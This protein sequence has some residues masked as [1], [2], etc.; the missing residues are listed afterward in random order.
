[1]ENA[2]NALLMAA[3]VLIGVMIISLAVYLFHSFADYSREMNIK[4]E[5]TILDEFNN[6]FLK[7][8]DTNVTLHDILGLASLAKKYDDEN[9]LT[10]S[11][12]DEDGEKSTY[13]RIDIGNEKFIEQYSEEK[14]IKLIKDRSLNIANNDFRY[15]KCIAGNYRIG[16]NSKRI[17]YMKFEEI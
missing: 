13:I 5:A 15:Y 11:D 17:Y 1:M 2:S 16:P 7:Y 9:E 12:Y 8:T 14:I 6:Q 10:E 3:E 4:M